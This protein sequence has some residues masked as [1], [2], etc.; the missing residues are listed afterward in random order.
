MAR[1]DVTSGLQCTRFHG[2]AHRRVMERK[3]EFALLETVDDGLKALF[4]GL[5]FR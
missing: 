1:L 4:Q 5:K 3:A 2:C